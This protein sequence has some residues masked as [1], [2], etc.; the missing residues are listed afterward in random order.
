MF[1]SITLSNYALKVVLESV[2]LTGKRSFGTHLDFSI[3]AGNGIFKNSILTFLQNA[4]SSRIL[5]NHVYLSLTVILG[6]TS[7]YK[8]FTNQ[9]GERNRGIHHLLTPNHNPENSALI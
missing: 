3:R 1:H 4:M 2:F 9:H 5:H 7:P 8:W 6:K